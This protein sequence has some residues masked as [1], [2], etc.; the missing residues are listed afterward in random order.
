MS[1]WV[2]SSCQLHVGVKSVFLKTNVNVKIIGHVADLQTIPYPHM[3][4]FYQQSDTYFTYPSFPK[5]S[6][7]GTSLTFLLFSAYSITASF[8]STCKT[9]LEYLVFL[10]MFMPTQLYDK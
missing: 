6:P 3:I 5:S 10:K 9:L 1:V 7:V 2:E 8:S 4:E